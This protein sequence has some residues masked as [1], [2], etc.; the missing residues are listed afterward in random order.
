MDESTICILTVV[1]I[2]VIV[3]L[4]IN[5]IKSFRKNGVLKLSSE[6]LEY[7]DILDYITELCINFDD[8]NREKYTN[9]Q[10]VVISTMEY[11]D[12]MMNGGMC[13]FFT[14]SSRIFT[15]ILSV[16]LEEVNAIEHKNH[17][18]NFIKQNKINIDNL[19][20]FE[21]EDVDEFI[22]QYDRYPFKDFDGQFYD[23]DRTEKLCELI[24]ERALELDLHNPENYFKDCSDKKLITMCNRRGEI[25]A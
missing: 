3:K 25:K 17:F 13:Q 1:F 14:N 4:I 21:F 10:L 22:G 8:S 7:N 16:S 18:D 15:P 6:Q 12:E 24:N 9:Q 11:Y 5:N 23:I 2:I 20:S 19:N